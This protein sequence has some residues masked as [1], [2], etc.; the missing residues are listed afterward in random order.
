MIFIAM[1]N[2]LWREENKEHVSDYNKRYYAEHKQ[3]QSKRVK[4]RKEKI[5]K[6]ME[7][8]KLQLKCEKCGANHI[9]VLQFHHL[10]PNQKDE[11]VSSMVYRGWSIE[12]IQKEIEKCKVLC[13]N[14]HFILH[15]END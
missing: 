10:D 12:K 7:N 11:S 5:R 4:K 2:E 3:E 8:Q 15:Y 9:A 1:S 13:A 14:C 6:W